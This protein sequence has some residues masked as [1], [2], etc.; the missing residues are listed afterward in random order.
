MNSDF[1]KG[2]HPEDIE[3]LKQ[4]SESVTKSMLQMGVSMRAA[5]NKVVEA[6]GEFDKIAYAMMEEQYLKEFGQLPDASRESQKFAVRTWYFS[7]K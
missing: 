6:A 3:K 1:Y 2:M 5:A 7:K 4:I